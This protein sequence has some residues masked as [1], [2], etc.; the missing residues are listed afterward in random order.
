MANALQSLGVKSGHKVCLFLTSRP[1]FMV[2]YFACQKLV[3][4][5]VEVAVPVAT[6]PLG[7]NTAAVA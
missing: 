1:E 6:N 4:A 5:S 2:A 3:S 7:R